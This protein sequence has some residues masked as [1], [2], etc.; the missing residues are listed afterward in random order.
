MPGTGT[1][2]CGIMYLFQTLTPLDDL[3]FLFGLC[4]VEGDQRVCDKVLLR[5]ELE[6]H[7][8]L[9]KNFLLVQ[10]EG[11]T[12]LPSHCGWLLSRIQRIFLRKLSCQLLSKMKGGHGNTF[13]L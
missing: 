7:L 1:G 2:T 6:L 5:R 3:L 9:R 11:G 4:G 12:D 8:S 13:T 10:F